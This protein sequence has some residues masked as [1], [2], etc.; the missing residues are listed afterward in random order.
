MTLMFLNLKSC[1]WSKKWPKVSGS[2]QRL[3]S[4]ALCQEAPSLHRLTGA[5]YARD[6]IRNSQEG[7]GKCQGLI[8]I[9]CCLRGENSIFPVPKI[10]LLI[11]F[12]IGI[13]SYYFY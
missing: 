2:G 3:L 10:F 5:R 8:C 9:C 1:H 12:G 13:F 4:P 11:L 7:R 6:A